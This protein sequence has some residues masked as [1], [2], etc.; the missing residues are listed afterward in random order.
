MTNVGM[1]ESPKSGSIK[2]RETWIVA[3]VGLNNFLLAYFPVGGLI[4]IFYFLI[5]RNFI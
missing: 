3:N 2:D 5:R 1:T 4:F